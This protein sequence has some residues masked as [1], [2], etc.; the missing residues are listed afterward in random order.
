MTSDASSPALSSAE[1]LEAR[2]L[3]T[4]FMSSLI[5]FPD[6]VKP[7]HTK[8]SL[9]G[10]AVEVKSIPN[11]VV[12]VRRQYLKAIQA[13]IVARNRYQELVERKSTGSEERDDSSERRKRLQ[14]HLRL[15]QLRRR[16]EEVQITKHYFEKL[17]ADNSVVDGQL[18]RL[19][20]ARNHE[21][22]AN[23]LQDYD[24]TGSD[25]TAQANSEALTKEL[26][27]ALLEAKHQLEREKKL[28]ADVKARRD[29]AG[30]VSDN[31]PA[32]ARVHAL[33]ATK[34]ELVTFLDDRLTRASVA[35]EKRDAVRNEI[36]DDGDNDFEG[37]HAQINAQY[38]QY[39]TVRKRLLAAA[40]RLGSEA[41]P[42][43]PQPPPVADPSAQPSNPPP[44][45]PSTLPFI[46]SQLLPLLQQHNA[47]KTQNTYLSKTLSQR[48]A[49]TH[50]VLERL[51]DESHLLPAYPL[52]A[53][54]ERF[55]NAAAAVLGSGGR[56]GGDGEEGDELV[57]RA[58]AWAFAAG[59][60]GLAEE[61]RVRERVGRGVRALEGAGEVLGEIEGVV[62]EGEREG[63]G[64]RDA[65]RQSREVG[66][67]SR[68]RI[69]SEEMKRRPWPGVRGDVGVADNE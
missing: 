5:I 20:Q 68:S 23:G 3:L 60:A 4:T 26:E 56:G 15:L 31:P 53:R 47:T 14:T 44:P 27:I 66:M 32:D 49:A 28:L 1:V 18:D 52:M 38:E 39:I 42:P 34:N 17:T 62:R 37:L 9:P 22:D 40:S 6:N 63:E 41:P 57:R 43:Q 61:E 54:E 13:N 21:K 35:E 7:S 11:E 45:P 65:E 58:R 55:R 25:S 48:R 51:A 46:S 19:S 59:E 24:R 12:G 2:K 8:L 50:D 16:H 36:E 29:Y 10:D 30:S 69:Q 33:S 67:K 64:A